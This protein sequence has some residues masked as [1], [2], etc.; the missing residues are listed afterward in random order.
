MTKAKS[1]RMI[2]IEL[3]EGEEPQLYWNKE[4]KFTADEIKHIQLLLQDVITNDN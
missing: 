2:L 3:A 1:K 4:E